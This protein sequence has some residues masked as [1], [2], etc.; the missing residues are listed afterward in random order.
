MTMD[1]V[2][3]FIAF[4]CLLVFLGVIVYRVPR[5]DLALVVGVTLVLVMRDL[6]L[7]LRPRRQ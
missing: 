2:F 6:W 3:A 1:R 7:Q 5:L 4:A